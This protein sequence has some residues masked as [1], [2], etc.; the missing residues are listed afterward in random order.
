MGIR[1]WM[2]CK[3]RNMIVYTRFFEQEEEQEEKK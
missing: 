3:N 1:D 2:W